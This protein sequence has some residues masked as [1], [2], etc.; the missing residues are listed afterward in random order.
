[1]SSATNCRAHNDNGVALPTLI[2]ATLLLSHARGIRTGL[3]HC[4]VTKKS[5]SELKQDIENQRS[6]HHWSNEVLREVFEYRICSYLPILARLPLFQ[7]IDLSSPASSQH[8]TPS[9]AIHK[10]VIPQ[11]LTPSS[12]LLHQRFNQ[13]QQLPIQL[14]YR[15][16]QPLIPP[17][18]LMR[19]NQPARQLCHTFRPTILHLD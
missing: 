10:P 13:S 12:R 14:C 18:T 5:I 4:L 2:R 9:T 17:P 11:Q 8:L 15:F 3:S 7:T 19:R 6:V 1:M 16:H